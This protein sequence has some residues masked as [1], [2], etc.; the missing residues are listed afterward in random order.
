MILYCGFRLHETAVI[1]RTETH[2]LLTPATCFWP[3]Y[4]KQQT[5]PEWN[6]IKN[7]TCPHKPAKPERHFMF[8]EAET[9]VSRGGNI[10]FP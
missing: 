10:R 9:Y 4:P 2:M 5:S 1:P 7:K 3:Q 8:S 6:K